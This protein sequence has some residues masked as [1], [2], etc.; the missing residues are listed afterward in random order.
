MTMTSW[1]IYTHGPS[2][3]TSAATL[4]VVILLVEHLIGLIFR[5]STGIWNHCFG[6]SV[7]GLY[8][9]RSKIILETRDRSSRE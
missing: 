7:G 8:T 4:Y 5:L 6:I 3:I 2:F 1:D 9:V